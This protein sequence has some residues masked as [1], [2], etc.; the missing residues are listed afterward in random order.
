MSTIRTQFY[1]CKIV[2]PVRP[3]TKNTPKNQRFQPPAFAMKIGTAAAD[4]P[5][6]YSPEAAPRPTIP[7]KPV[8]WAKAPRFYGKLP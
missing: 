5:E 2:A 4:N 6:S 1:F 3:S 7:F 8:Y